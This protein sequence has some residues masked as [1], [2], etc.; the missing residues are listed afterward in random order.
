MADMDVAA[1]YA[2]GDAYEAPPAP[3]RRVHREHADV[4]RQSVCLVAFL[5][6]S[7]RFCPALQTDPA[8][9]DWTSLS[10]CP[11]CGTLQP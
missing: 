1:A 3:R 10:R 4:V 6:G 9:Q 2:A 8:V 5:A 7:V 11:T